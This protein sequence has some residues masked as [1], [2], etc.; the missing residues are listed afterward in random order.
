MAGKHLPWWKFEEIETGNVDLENRPNVS[1]P[2]GGRSSVLSGS[3]NIDGVEVLI[4]HVSKGPRARV[5]SSEEALALYRKT[6]KHLGKFR[7][8][9]AATAAGRDIHVGQVEMGPQGSEK[10]ERWEALRTVLKRDRS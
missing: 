9:K 2:G 1:N 10:R 3:Y 6:G 7:S 4:P 8:A 5:L